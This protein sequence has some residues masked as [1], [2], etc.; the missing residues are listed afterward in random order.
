MFCW[1]KNINEA[2]LKLTGVANLML[3]GLFFTLLWSS[4]AIAA[5]IGL[6]AA[7][8][9]TL[10]TIRFILAGMLL[11]VYVYCLNRKKFLWPQREE[12][13]SLVLLGFLN[14][15]LYLGLSFWALKSVSAGLFNL[16]VTA[17]PFVV[18][19]LS[20]VWLKRTILPREWT[21]MVVAGTGLFIATYP[22]LTSSHATISGLVLLGVGM[23]S[24]AVGSVY[25]HKVKLNLPSIVINTWQV[26]IGGIL[27]IPPTFLFE[28]EA[29]VKV[30]MFFIGSLIWLVLAV[31][32]G[33]MLLWFY[34]LKQDT[35]KANNWLFLTPV[36]GYVLAAIF[37]KE[38]I[39]SQDI[40][41]TVLVFI[42][43]FLSGNIH[44]QRTTP[45][46]LKESPKEEISP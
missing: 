42:G 30:D 26:T 36:S 4:A 38:P 19:L 9:L 32:I 3:L 12:W 1:I 27:L 13:R 37:L 18:A 16:F 5:K 31:S 2:F 41:A 45:S 23:I 14:T 46:T 24:M 22:S 43:L 15:T 34:L 21:G 44:F 40:I 39:T 7:P 28:S 8:P 20:F 17:N 10:A 11:F 6:Q 25:F 33:A 35:V 29:S